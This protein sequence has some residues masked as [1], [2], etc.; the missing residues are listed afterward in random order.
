MLLF[1]LLL[2]ILILII[3]K[4]NILKNY[5]KVDIDTML[6][7]G[8]LIEQ[9]LL[10]GNIFYKSKVKKDNTISYF[11]YIR[12]E[13]GEEITVDNLDIYSS[14]VTAD[15]IT[16]NKYLYKYREY[17]YS[18]YTICLDHLEDIKLKEELNIIK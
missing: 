10:R 11:V 12:L 6:N 1:F 8:D 7:N 15:V 18:Y 4:F 9:S 16:F 5:N 14:V 3:F 13:N 2:L 17:N